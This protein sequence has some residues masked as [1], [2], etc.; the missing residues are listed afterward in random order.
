MHDQDKDPLETQEWV[1]SLE[2]VIHHTG[3]GRAAY[4]LL[5]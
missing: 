5:R 2:S 3:R 4:L 1:D